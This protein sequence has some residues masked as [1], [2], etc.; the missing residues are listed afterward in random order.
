MDT[1]K[2]VLKP[3]IRPDQCE[4]HSDGLENENPYLCNLD[5][6]ILTTLRMDKFPPRLILHLSAHLSDDLLEGLPSIDASDI[7]VSSSRILYHFFLND[8]PEDWCDFLWQTLCLAELINHSMYDEWEGRFEFLSFPSPEGYVA[9]LT[10]CARNHGFKVRDKSDCSI[11]LYMERMPTC[12]NGSVFDCIIGELKAVNAEML[13][14]LAQKTVLQ[15]LA[16][17]K[18]LGFV[19]ETGEN[20]EEIHTN[21]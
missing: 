5:Y 20:D 6:S 1:T 12:V 15:D 19:R 16:V 7:E 14:F 18:K 13:T 2:P 21:P 3:G 4:L 9:K 11:D 17:G 10:S 8:P